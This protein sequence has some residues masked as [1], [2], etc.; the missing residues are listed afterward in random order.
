MNVFLIFN[1]L[2]DFILY[3]DKLVYFNNVT[4]YTIENLNTTNY[5]AISS[6]KNI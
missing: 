5:M 3:A 4:N 1:Y 6:Y 2:L